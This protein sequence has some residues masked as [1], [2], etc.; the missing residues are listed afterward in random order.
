M[1][2]E[3]VLHGHISA[4]DK[5]IVRYEL[6]IETSAKIIE[7]RFANICFVPDEYISDVVYDA[8]SLSSEQNKYL[9]TSSKN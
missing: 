8:M 7:H 1:T 2:H 9:T 6:A 3:I 4:S 5:C